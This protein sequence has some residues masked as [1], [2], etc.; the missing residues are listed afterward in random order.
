MSHDATAAGASVSAAA[1]ADDDDAERMNDDDA[2]ADAVN[3]ARLT[4]DGTRR[5]NS[6]CER[7][8]PRCAP[9]RIAH[10]VGATRTARY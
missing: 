3:A 10:I 9:S 7:L 2:V 1:A 6:N 4:C 8:E 5:V